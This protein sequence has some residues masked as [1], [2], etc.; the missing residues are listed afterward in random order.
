[1]GCRKYLSALLVFPLYNLLYNIY[2][3]FSWWFRAEPSP[4]EEPF[5]WMFFTI[6][7]MSMFYQSCW[8]EVKLRT[9]RLSS[10][11]IILSSLCNAPV[12]LTAKQ[13]NRLM[14]SKRDS[15]HCRHKQFSVCLIFAPNHS[16][17]IS[18]T[19]YKLEIRKTK[20][21]VGKFTQWANISLG[22]LLFQDVIF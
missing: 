20:C 14:L 11:F 9:R 16:F 22:S 1:M 18:L 17:E 3:V 10:I 21:F 7:V 4:L 6:R 19:Y 2:P 5:H 13:P 12:P 15:K 8:F